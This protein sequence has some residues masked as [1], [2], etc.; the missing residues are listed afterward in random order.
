MNGHLPLSIPTAKSI[1]MSRFASPALRRSGNSIC[2]PE[3]YHLLDPA[4]A[5][6]NQELAF[7][8]KKTTGLQEVQNRCRVGL[9]PGG[10]LRTVSYEEDF[11]IIGCSPSPG[12][13]WRRGK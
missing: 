8:A 10:F 2:I 3:S 9:K 7:A 5:S 12:C 6:I 1:M 11:C 4:P 13:L